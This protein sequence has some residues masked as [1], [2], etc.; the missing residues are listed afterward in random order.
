MRARSSR[1]RGGSGL[2]GGPS[3]DRGR[4]A[5][6]RG[7]GAAHERPADGDRGGLEIQAAMAGGIELRRGEVAV[8]NAADLPP[9]GPD[10][11]GA[12]VLFVSGAGAE[13]RAAVPPGGGRDRG[14]M[15]GSAARP[16]PVA[17]DGGGVVGEAFRGAQQG[18]RRGGQGRAMRGRAVA[19]DRTARGTGRP[20]ACAASSLNASTVSSV[21]RP[22]NPGGVVPN[23]QSRL[24]THFNTSISRIG[25]SKMSLSRK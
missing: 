1:N 10:D 14:G 23:A 19:G 11:P 22:T 16:G 24:A 4:G 15:G 17:G 5:V 2:A 13:E 21:R 9:P 6:R 12:C 18:L 20:G 8:A 3:Q 7:L 25:M